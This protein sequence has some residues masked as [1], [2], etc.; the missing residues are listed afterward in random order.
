M[1]ERKFHHGN[2]RAALLELAE[3]E[4]ERRGYES[5]LLSDLAAALGVSS[6]A[7]YR[8]FESKNALLL[9]LAEIGAE[10][11]RQLYQNAL[12][13]DAEPATR[14]RVACQS[15]LDFAKNRP[16]LFRLL[17]ISRTDW[18][19]GGG[20]TFSGPTSGFGLFRELVTASLGG[21]PYEDALAETMVTWS[22]IHGF[23]MLRLNDRVATFTEISDLR[24][25]EAAVLDRA[26]GPQ[27]RPGL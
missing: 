16:E 20:E 15:Y 4:L 26:C 19:S 24:A 3:S 2:L 5:L 22:V 8:H 23:A 13:L 9:A 14:L 10:Q 6:A 25:C 1:S 18:Y 7:P 17:F 11:L 12:D 27:D 21:R